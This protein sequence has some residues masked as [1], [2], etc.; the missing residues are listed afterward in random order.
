V[1]SLS[2]NRKILF[3]S[4][5]CLS[6]FFPSVWIWEAAVFLHCSLSAPPRLGTRVSAAKA[7]LVFSYLPRQ[8]AS[9]FDLLAC[10]IHLHF[11]QALLCSRC[12]ISSWRSCPA[13]WGLA[14]TCVSDLLSM[15][16]WF[17]SS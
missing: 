10:L 6:L 7:N 11:P 8:S 13:S 1:I 15:W 17:S 3:S 14:A 12:F 16:R 2:L 9:F 4:F 5:A